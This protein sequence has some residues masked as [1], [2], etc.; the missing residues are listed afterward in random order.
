M[1]QEVEKKGRCT[2]FDKIIL[3]L[4]LMMLL[5]G[6]GMIAVPA[7]LLWGMACLIFL[8]LSVTFRRQYQ[9]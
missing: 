3:R 9:G 5:L 1:Q 2:M 8:A 6:I 4:I 7:P